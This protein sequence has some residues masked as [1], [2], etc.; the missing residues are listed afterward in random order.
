[1]SNR[2]LFWRWAE[3]VDSSSGPDAC[4]EWRRTK[5]PDGYGVLWDGARNRGAH[6]ISWDLHNPDEPAAGKSVLHKC[7]NP[8]CVNPHHLFLGT[9]SD[10]VNDMVSKGRHG[11]TKLTAAQVRQVR[12]A[13]GPQTEIAKKFGISQAQVSR[14]KLGQR[15]TL[16]K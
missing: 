2:S 7:D 11:F 16:V 14:I 8:S 10:N 9:Q 12:K 4:W 13:K 1:M 6:I 15:R 5:Y 3:K